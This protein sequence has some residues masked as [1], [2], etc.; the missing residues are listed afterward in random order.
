[1][2]RR[3]VLDNQEDKLV[4]KGALRE[5]VREL[6]RNPETGKPLTRALFGCRTVRIGDCRLVYRVIRHDTGD[7]IE[8][9]AIGRRRDDEIYDTAEARI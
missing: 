6:E 3:E 7:M 8:I 5:K 4:A 1:M 9:I 2:F